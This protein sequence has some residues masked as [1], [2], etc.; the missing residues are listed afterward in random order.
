MGSKDGKCE[1]ALRNLTSPLSPGSN[2]RL[3]ESKVSGTVILFPCFPPA[4]PLCSCV[5]LPDLLE[6][7]EG[8]GSYTKEQR[9]LL[10]SHL[11]DPEQR[12]HPWPAKLDVAFGIEDPEEVAAR[13]AAAAAAAESAGGEGNGGA[14]AEAA[15]GEA[16][17]ARG[18]GTEAGSSPKG[19]RSL[20]S[21]GRGCSGGSRGNASRGPGGRFS[22]KGRRAGFGDKGGAAAGGM[23]A[24]AG[25]IVLLGSPMVDA[26]LD[27][28]EGL[29][30][31]IEVLKREMGLANNANG[32]GT[33]MMEVCA[34]TARVVGQGRDEG[35]R[36]VFFFFA[37]Y[38][39]SF[40]DLKVVALRLAGERE[41]RGGGKSVR[42][43]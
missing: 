22:S 29:K 39:W 18:D 15:G 5:R 41:G 32:E 33:V 25:G 27:D 8:T 42:V 19:G 31:V 11:E 14:K 17:A 43:V 26:T 36:V 21:G 16:G 10:V 40:V 13:E 24:S 7:Y 9:C 23:A 34:C 3:E 6:A 37:M 30:E 38:G 28:T 1:R 35:M 20:P 2:A 4:V 12:K